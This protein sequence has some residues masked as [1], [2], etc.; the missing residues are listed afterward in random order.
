M[1]QTMF[2]KVNLKLLIAKLTQNILEKY[3]CIKVRQVRVSVYC[4]LTLNNAEDGVSILLSGHKIH[5][6]TCH[7]VHT[8]VTAGW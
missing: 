8:S 1:N 4:F 6:N 5:H 3:L 2:V 7:T